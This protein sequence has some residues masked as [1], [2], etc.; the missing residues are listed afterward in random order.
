MDIGYLTNVRKLHSGTHINELTEQLHDF[1]SQ[2]ST[3]TH[4]EIRMMP[5]SD[6]R[7]QLIADVPFTLNFIRLFVVAGIL[8]LFSAIFNFLNLHFDLF[9]QRIRE[10]RLRTLHGASV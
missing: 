4:H 9:R 8:L 1:T 10:F 6:V 7:Y 2:L 5:V 3:N